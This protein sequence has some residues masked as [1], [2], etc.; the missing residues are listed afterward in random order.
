MAFVAPR[1][2][3]RSGKILRATMKK[4]ADHDPWSTPATLEDPKALEEIKTALE[5]RAR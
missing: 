5:E 1:L 3:N 4:I 2:P